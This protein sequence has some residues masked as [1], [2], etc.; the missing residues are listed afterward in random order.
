VDRVVVDSVERF[1]L[2][3]D[4]LRG[5]E[6]EVPAAGT[7]SS[8][9]SLPIDGWLLGRTAATAV[10]V[11]Q[12][13]HVVLRLPVRVS[14][15]DLRG[16][17]PDDEDAGAAGFSGAVGALR[18]RAKFELLLRGRLADGSTLPLAT[19]RGSR[20]PLQLPAAE[21]PRPLI[22]TTLGRTG[23]TWCVWML[24]SHPAIVAHSPFENDARVG[25]YWMSALQTLADPTSYLRQVFPG[26]VTDPQ[27]WVGMEAD[28]PSRLNDGALNSWLG[29]SRIYE[30]AL[31]CR[32]RIDSF[33]EFLAERQGK[34][35]AFFVEKFLPRQIPADLL[36][37][38]YPGAKEVVL[39]RDLRDVYCSVLSFNRKRG[40]QAF[41]R[42]NAESDEDY[43]DNVRRSG[44][45]L[46]A[47][48]RSEGR[49][50]HLLRYEDLI[51]E[52]VPTLEPLLE[53][54][55]LDPAGAP[56]MVER[57]SVPADGMEHH[58]TAPNASASIGRWRSDL[59]PELAERCDS[60]LSPVA[61]DFGYAAAE[62]DAPVDA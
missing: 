11:L 57:A 56:A 4:Q 2:A 8:L 22:V 14:R 36:R 61:A 30:L 38:V 17:F 34:Q 62:G 37:E 51:R 16:A 48:M 27:W 40:Y 6:L 50:T 23:S 20:E 26:D 41:G 1:P 15:Q 18:L 35:P 10:E 42:E 31:S 33:Y 44:E 60:I 32:A 47:H 59:E 19:I 9:Q 28:T 3:E 52:P 13:G 45:A 49:E 12:E 53:F 46:L 54:L 25:T 39:V 55:G 5:F 24:Q 43:I 58:M 21:G 29:D 7:T